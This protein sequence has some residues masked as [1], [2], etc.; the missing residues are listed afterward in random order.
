MQFLE[1]D[2]SQATCNGIAADCDAKLREVNRA[3]ETERRRRDTLKTM[4]KTLFGF[5]V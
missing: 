4:V 1:A 5:D 3:L 2:K